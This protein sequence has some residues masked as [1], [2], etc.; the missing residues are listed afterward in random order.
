MSSHHSQFPRNLPSFRKEPNSQFTVE[1]V[2]L[3]PSYFPLFSS[4]ASANDEQGAKNVTLTTQ[5]SRSNARRL[6][7]IKWNFVRRDWEAGTTAH[8]QNRVRT[9]WEDGVE[10]MPMALLLHLFRSFQP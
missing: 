3:A 10:A 9:P 6:I 1:A 2:P 8:M 7:V 4:S 5:R